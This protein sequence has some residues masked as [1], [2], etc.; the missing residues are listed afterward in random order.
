MSNGMLTEN[1]TLQWILLNNLQMLYAPLWNR[2]NFFLCTFSRYDVS[3]DI[4]FN[5][6]RS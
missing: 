3:Y 4:H 1:G 6:I 5:F 2:L